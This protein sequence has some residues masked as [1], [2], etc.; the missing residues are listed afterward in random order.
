[1]TYDMHVEKGEEGDVE[2]F[3]AKLARLLQDQ[4]L[5]ERL[6]DRGRARARDV[7]SW[8]RVA[9]GVDRMYRESVAGTSADTHYE[10]R[11]Q[12]NT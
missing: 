4:P 1:M 12:E 5:R 10:E 8:E 6:A 9:E 7:L 3:A 11:A 2:D